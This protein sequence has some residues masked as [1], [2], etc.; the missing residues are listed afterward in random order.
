MTEGSEQRTVAVV[1]LQ[2]GKSWEPLVK[3]DFEWAN[4]TIM[5]LSA[6]ISVVSFVK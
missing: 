4:A 5:L 1:G 3:L 2:V 6:V